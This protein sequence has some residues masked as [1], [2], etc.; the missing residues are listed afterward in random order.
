MPL[1]IST[2]KK[3]D[4]LL[5]W[6]VRWGAF[7]KKCFPG[8]LKHTQ[9]I[10]LEIERE[11]ERGRDDLRW[12]RW[13]SGHRLYL[14]ILFMENG[15]PFASPKFNRQKNG[16][17]TLLSFY[18]PV[19]VRVSFYSPVTVRGEVLNLQGVTSFS[20]LFHWCL[21]YFRVGVWRLGQQDAL[22]KVKASTQLIGIYLPV[23]IRVR[24]VCHKDT[25]L[26]VSGWSPRDI[27]SWRFWI[28][29]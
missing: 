25:K 15:N 11:R 3:H 16:W 17:T 27:C 9:N 22:V 5:S 13:N 2:T 23:S 21:F 20:F 8:I 18:S 1:K 29:F 7:C 4:F 10:H 28:E 24:I 19:T 6:S 12:D 14:F 26:H